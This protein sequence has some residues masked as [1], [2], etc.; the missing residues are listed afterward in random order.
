MIHSFA[1]R[2]FCSFADDVEL[3]FTVGEQ[4]PDND[5]FVRTQ[6]GQRLSKALAVLGPNASGKTNLLKGLPFLS[7]FAVHSFRGL[8]A[9]DPIPFD[10]FQFTEER[11][12]KTDFCVVFEVDDSIYRYELTLSRKRV[13][14]EGLFRKHDSHFRYLFKRE[15]TAA[16]GKPTILEKGFGFSPETVQQLVRGNASLLSV[17]R[18]TEHAPSRAILA[19]FDRLQTNVMYMGRE[20][21]E[22]LDRMGNLLRATDFFVKR[23]D[24]KQ[25]VDRLLRESDLGLTA[26]HF[27]PTK[28]RDEKGSEKEV[29][30]PY[31][32]HAVDGQ[33]YQLPLFME[34]DGTQNLFTL[35]SRIL[36]VLEKGGLA[37]MDEFEVDLHPHMIPAIVGLFFDPTTNPHSA[38]LLFS[39]HSIDVMR[40]LD[41]TQVVLVEK[42]DRCRS[43]AWRL[44]T[45]KGVRRQHNLYAKYMS[46][47]YGAVPNV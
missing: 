20:W 5:L 7:W 14:R 41:K 15:A 25:Q 13:E 10:A 43:T 38:Q 16:E 28:F 31:A 36:P 45:V 18:Q 27:K 26:T 8:D 42:D 44:D 6:G 30:M 32:V 11:D 22:P 37:V 33:E 1:M 40:V 23:D 12:G 4:A 39:T 19:Y 17:L 9:D 46:G 21:H 34:S 3:S 47:A 29:V 24:L 35:A 2:N